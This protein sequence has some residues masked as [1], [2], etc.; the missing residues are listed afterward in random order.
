MINELTAAIADYKTKWESLVA[1]RA[2][3]SFF[4]NLKPTAVAWK[5][6]DIAD[7]DARM[8]ELRDLCDQIFVVWMN[9]R[10]IAKLH[11]KEGMLPWNLRIIKLMQR[12]P[13]STDATGLDH[14]DF[15]TPD[16]SA[17]KPALSGETELK[18]NYEKNNAEW[19]SVW[20]AGGEAK[21]RD[22]TICGVC[23]NELLQTEKEILA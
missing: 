19:Y 3:V 10:W 5:T 6:K 9:D 22:D 12:R 13:G 14:I 21:I 11:L 4:E 2:D 16:G 23:A 8:S 1:Q 15:Y 20:S 7:Y 18:W 17:I